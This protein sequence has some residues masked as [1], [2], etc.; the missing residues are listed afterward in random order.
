MYICCSKFIKDHVNNPVHVTENMTY[1]F[2]LEKMMFRTSEMMIVCRKNVILDMTNNQLDTWKL[3]CLH[4][5][6]V[7]F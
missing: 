4:G 6:V 7:K 3:K 2:I 5:N 1:F